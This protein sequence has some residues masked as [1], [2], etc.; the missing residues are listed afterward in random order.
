[1]RRLAL[2]LALPL[3]IA[4]SKN[5]TPAADTSAMSDASAPAPANFAGDWDMSV[6]RQGSDSIIVHGVMHTTNDMNGW[7]MTL[8]G[9]P[10]VDVRVMSMSGDAAVAQAGPYPSALRKNTMVTVDMNM[11]FAGNMMNGTSVAHYDTK[12]ADSVVALTTTAIRK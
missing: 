5:E 10:T 3:A 6:M 4:C 11:Q 12:A 7:T 9:Q 8:D 1:M 2:I